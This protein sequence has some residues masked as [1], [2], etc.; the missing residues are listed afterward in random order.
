[1]THVCARMRR[2]WPDY[3]SNRAQSKAQDGQT[4]CCYTSPVTAFIFPSSFQVQVINRDEKVERRSI[5]R[6]RRLVHGGVG[7]G[8]PGLAIP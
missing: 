5:M 8:A 2:G 3:W 7:Q 4:Q 6:C 1:M